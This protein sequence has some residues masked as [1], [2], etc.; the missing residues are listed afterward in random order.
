[1]LQ[2]VIRLLQRAAFHRKN[3]ILW[4]MTADINSS[5]PVYDALATTRHY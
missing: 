5:L 3:N 4:C 1:M 2:A